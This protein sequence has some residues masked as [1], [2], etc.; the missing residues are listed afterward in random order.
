MALPVEMQTMPVA[1]P[2]QKGFTHVGSDWPDDIEAAA[3]AERFGLNP[4]QMPQFKD[5]QLRQALLSKPDEQ[6]DCAARFERVK[7]VNE[8]CHAGMNNQITDQ[9]SS[10]EWKTILHSSTDTEVEGLALVG[11]QDLLQSSHEPVWGAGYASFVKTES[12]RH[13]LNLAFRESMDTFQG[14]ETWGE[15]HF[16][17]CWIKC[18]Q[19]L[20]GSYKYQAKKS[21]SIKYQALNVNS[22]VKNISVEAVEESQLVAEAPLGELPRAAV[23]QC[24][25]GCAGKVDCSCLTR[26]FGWKQIS[27]GEDW[28]VSFTDIATAEQKTCRVL[29]DSTQL[30]QVA[31]PGLSEAISMPESRSQTKR[32]LFLVKVQCIIAGR[33]QHGQLIVHPKEPLDKIIKFAREVGEHAKAQFGAGA[34][35]FGIEEQT[36]SQDGGP[37]ESLTTSL[38]GGPGLSSVQTPSS[39]G[40][41][42]G[43]VAGSYFLM[44]LIV[45][46]LLI[47]EIISGDDKAIPTILAG[48]V[49]FYLFLLACFGLQT[50]R[51]LSCVF[52]VK[53]TGVF[54]GSWAFVYFLLQT[55]GIEGGEGV[56]QRAILAGTVIFFLLLFVCFVVPTMLGSR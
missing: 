28:N 22:Q 54:L 4:P 31:F 55:E 48:T 50:V 29:E 49:L 45:A 14:R 53:F 3:N 21:Q 8:A 41:N 32:R 1:A 17:C 51:S 12:Q 6:A 13:V 47:N 26:G 20:G 52:H 44:L 18:T 19:M 39:L 24:C 40:L 36:S 34:E 35:K 25:A 2:Q 5:G 16:Y 30:K 27:E 42:A 38:G 56:E 46:F 15:R 37:S 33:P 9:P 7:Q 23:E 43:K 11:M 10:A